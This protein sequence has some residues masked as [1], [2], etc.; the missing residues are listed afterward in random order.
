MNLGDRMPASALLK[1]AAPVIF[2]LTSAL[3]A[4]ACG[5]AAAPDADTATSAPMVVPPTTVA[6]VPTAAPAE[7]AATA[8]AP[9]PTPTYRATPTETPTTPS[10]MAPTVAHTPSPMPPTL[11]QPQASCETGLIITSPAD[12]TGVFSGDTVL[13]VVEPEAGVVVYSVLLVGGSGGA[14]G[15][16]AAVVD[17]SSPFEFNFPIPAEAVGAFKL[18][19]IGSD[20]IGNLGRSGN[21]FGSNKVTLQVTPLAALESMRLIP[22]NAILVT[23]G[24]SRRFGVLGNFADGIVRD[25]TS[26]TAGTVYLTTDPSIFNITPS[27]LGTSVSA[28][29]VT[30]VAQNAGL[31]DT[32]NVRVLLPNEVPIANAGPDQEVTLESLVTLD[33]SGSFDA[34]VGQTLS[35]EWFQVAGPDVSLS[36]D[37]TPT[38]TFTPLLAGSYTF[39]LVVRDAQANSKP[40]GVT[41]TV[42]DGA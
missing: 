35:F 42:S 16:A 6:G 23:T 39:G 26:P 34:D 4:V 29:I 33:G 17:E 1:P 19:A 12:G 27:G 13:V 38:P 37:T 8:S 20:S 32:V 9:T 15:P 18:L 41:I 28:G 40:D 7:P 3:L 36:G 22:R 10:T 24:E 25:I 2:F 11:C 30:I 14:G 31:Q 21:L 5:P